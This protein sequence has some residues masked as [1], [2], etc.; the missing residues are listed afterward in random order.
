VLCGPVLERKIGH[1][2]HTQVAESLPCRT[3]TVKH[4]TTQS[5]RYCRNYGVGLAAYVLGLLLSALLDL[6]TADATR[7]DWCSINR[8]IR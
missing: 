1:A 2:G 8:A 6:S 5:C 4:I 3:L 7:F